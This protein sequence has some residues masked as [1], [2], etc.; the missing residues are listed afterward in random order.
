MKSLLIKS[1]TALSLMLGAAGIAQ[2]QSNVDMSLTGSPSGGG[3]YSG[4]IQ[5]ATINASFFSGATV[6]LPAQSVWIQ[7]SLPTGAQFDLTY[8]GIPAGWSY[9]YSDGQNVYLQNETTISLLTSVSFAIPFK[10]MAAIAAP[11]AGVYNTTSQIT[12]IN[13]SFNDPNVTNNT[14]LTTIS[15]NNVPLPLQFVA[16]T[17]KEDNCKADLT[18]TTVG[19]KNNDHFEIERSADG[20]HFASIGRVKSVN[21]T[22][23]KEYSYVDESPVKGHNF[24]RVRQVDIDAKSTTTSVQQ[25]RFDCAVDVIEM[26]PNPTSGI[27]YIKG[28]KDKAT[29]EVYNLLGQKMV[30]KKTENAIEGVNLNGLADGSYQVNVVNANNQII[31][32][33]K[34]VKK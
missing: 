17:A 11:A 12:L 13:P 16:F 29:V 20:E 25:V 34:L 33:A 6:N 7:F 21:A 1:F 10:V 22:E 4:F 27:I 15:V 9:N 28:L 30:T 14:V 32:T 26:Y 3:V 18:W 8:P 5:A 19:E 24:Y 2:A 31:F 23:A